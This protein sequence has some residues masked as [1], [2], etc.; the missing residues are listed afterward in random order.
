MHAD[1]QNCYNLPLLFLMKVARCIESTQNGNMIMFLEYI[2]KS[3]ATGFLFYCDAKH[4]DILQGSSY[5]SC[6]LILLFCVRKLEELDAFILMFVGDLCFLF[7]CLYF[8]CLFSDNAPDYLLKFRIPFTFV[9]RNTCPKE[10]FRANF[11]F[12][13]IV[14]INL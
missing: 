3:V 10:K 1:K 5:V 13:S 7:E 6:Y 4:S 12:Q 2:K 9:S 14:I 8:C 11:Q